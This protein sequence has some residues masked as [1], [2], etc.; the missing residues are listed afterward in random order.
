MTIFKPMLAGKFD[1]ALARFP[2]LASPKIDGFRIMAMG[3]YPMT[4]SMKVLPN[5]H[6]QLVFKAYADVL[7]GL[8]GELTVGGAHD[9]DTFERTT[10]A[11]RRK[12]GEPGFTY[13]VFDLWDSA[14]DYKDRLAELEARLERDDALDFVNLVAHTWIDDQDRLDAYE[15]ACLDAGYE[16]AMTRCPQ[17]PYKQGRSSTREGWLLKVKR[18]EDAEAEIIGFEEEMFN[19]NEAFKSELGRTKRSTNAEGLVGKGTMGALVVRG[20]NGQFK[21]ATFNI[22]TGFDA[23][24]RAAYWTDRDRMLG[25]AVTYKFFAVGAKDAPRHPVFKGVRAAV[26]LEAAA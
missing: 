2:V 15:A 25:M 11:L 16:G 22:G 26:E 1:P 13:H 21:G 8:D 10:S 6:T 20:L 17:G 7:E 9:P 5:E 23:S 24:Q 4:R 3:G 14:A 12:E 19:G 18:Y